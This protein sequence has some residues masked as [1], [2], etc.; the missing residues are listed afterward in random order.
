MKPLKTRFVKGY[1]M[2]VTSM[3][4]ACPTSPPLSW[5]QSRTGNSQAFVYYYDHRTPSSPDGAKHAAE[6]SYVFGNFGDPGGEPGPEDLAL[7]NLMQSYWIN[8]AET[9]N[10]NGSGLPHWPN[11]TEEDQKVLY[12]N[13]TT[14]SEPI[15]NLEKLKAFDRYYSWRRE[16]AGE[17]IGQ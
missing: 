3:V 7:S 9:G 2:C 1:L 10:P 8:F 13:A 11:F 4:A 12:F 6:I 16:Q 5:F 17:K 15:P 14:R